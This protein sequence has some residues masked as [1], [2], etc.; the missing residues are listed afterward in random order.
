MSVTFSSSRVREE[1]EKESN[2]VV[3]TLGYAYSSRTKRTYKDCVPEDTHL[4]LDGWTNSCQK[5]QLGVQG[6]SG[7]GMRGKHFSSSCNLLHSACPQ[8]IVDLPSCAHAL[9][10]GFN[11]RH[12]RHW[13]SIFSVLQL[14][15]PDQDFGK[16]QSDFVRNTLRF[17]LLIAQ[18]LRPPCVVSWYIGLPLPSPAPSAV[19]WHFHIHENVP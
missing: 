11:C 6:S 2:V 4:K 19:R 17:C 1:S 15:L 9:W 3:F 12:C 14:T 7:V 5:K 8:G 13:N 16:L 10:F 18:H